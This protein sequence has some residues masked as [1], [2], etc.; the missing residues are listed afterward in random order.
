VGFCLRVLKITGIV[1]PV[2]LVGWKSVVDLIINSEGRFN[3]Y[4]SY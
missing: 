4:E 2:T 1:T 3:D